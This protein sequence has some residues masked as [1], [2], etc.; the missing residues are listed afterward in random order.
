M[1]GN[2]SHIHHFK[3]LILKFLLNLLFLFFEA[4]LIQKIKIYRMAENHTSGDLGDMA[5]LTEEQRIFGVD[6][7]VKNWP[8]G[9]ENPRR[10]TQEPNII[11]I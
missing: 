11:M 4:S 9:T 1:A 10:K 7:M 2:V 5:Q 6:E 3:A 8:Y